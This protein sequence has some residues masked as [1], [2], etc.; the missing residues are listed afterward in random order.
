[1]QREYEIGIEKILEKIMAGSCPNPMK[2]TNFTSKKLN[3]PSRINT[4]RHTPKHM[5]IETSK[6]KTKTRKQQEKNN[7]SHTKEP[8]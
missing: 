5:L 7:S 3:I 1:M 6:T 2:N 8:Q 4:K